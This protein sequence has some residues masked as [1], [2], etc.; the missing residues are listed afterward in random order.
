[1]ILIQKGKIEAGDEIY[2]RLTQNGTTLS[3]LHDKTYG[4]SFNEITKKLRSLA[5]NPSGLVHIYVRNATRGWSTQHATVFCKS[6]LSILPRQT[7]VDSGLCEANGQ[8]RLQ[9]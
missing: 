5:G 3:E 4:S 9:F 7:L 8:L 2:A 6:L 1:M